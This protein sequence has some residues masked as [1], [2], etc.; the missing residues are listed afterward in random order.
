METDFHSAFWSSPPSL[1]AGLALARQ[2]SVVAAQVGRG[3][4]AVY[5]AATLTTPTQVVP[6]LVAV[7]SPVLARDVPSLKRRMQS[8][9]DRRRPRELALGRTPLPRALVL[10]TDVATPSI[11]TACEHE[12]LGLIDQKG[13]V[14]LAFG[15]AFIHVIGRGRA[16]RRSRTALFSGKASR[17]VRLL[18]DSPSSLFTAQRLA[19]ST[20]TS[21]VYTHGV[22]ARLI[23]LGFVER[24]SSPRGFV[25]RNPIGLLRAWL[26][27][28]ANPA[29]TVEAYNA[30][31]TTTAALKKADDARRSAGIAGIFTLASA[32]KADETFVGGLPHGLYLSGDSEP[33]V[34]A[35]GLRRISPANFLILRADPVV[36]TPAG[37]LF[38]SPR[39][40]PHGQGV[41]LAQ[42]AVD[43]ARAGGR[44]KEQAHSL[45]ERYAA[46][47]PLIGDDA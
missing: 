42:L 37:G 32:L 27:D 8:V 34:H 28:D 6:L 3:G 17:V 36:E 13:T 47:V 39:S 30:P 22:L 14:L 38:L 33:V 4:S 11:V 26:D 9:E 31:T 43:F 40:L 29:L 18:L 7:R 41:A 2:D 20:E 21:Y 19:A 25:C 23:D 1:P 5:D 46:S 10:A 35:L 12:G 24:R 16:A 45:L 15:G 44:G